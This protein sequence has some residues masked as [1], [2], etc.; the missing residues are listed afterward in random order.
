MWW[1]MSKLISRSHNKTTLMYHLVC[2][3]KY[4]RNVLTDSVTD[5]IVNVC[6]EIQEKYGIEFIEIGTDENHIHYLIQ[7]LPKYSPT[8][9]VTIIKSMTARMVFKVNP[10]VK[11]KLWGGEFWSDGY[12]LVTVGLNQSESVIREYVKNQGNGK[13]KTAH[14]KDDTNNII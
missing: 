12:W 6:M 14:K 13:Y 4:R 11:K 10:E 2:A 7:T 8:Q 3:V 1:E 5:T 9:F